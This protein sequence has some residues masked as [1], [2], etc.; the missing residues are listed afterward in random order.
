M[1]IC[2]RV[3]FRIVLTSNRSVFIIVYVPETQESL[4]VCAPGISHLFNDIRLY[5][6]QKVKADE[7]DIGKYKYF[8][9]FLSLWLLILNWKFGPWQLLKSNMKQQ[10]FTPNSILKRILLL[11]R[12]F[13]RQVFNTHCLPK[14]N[15]RKIRKNK[16]KLNKQRRL[17]KGQF[18]SFRKIKSINITTNT[19]T[20]TKCILHHI[21]FL[22]L[23]MI[24]VI[25]VF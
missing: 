3:D 20:C 15:I 8:S 25:P 10:A 16:R 18:R 6:K 21:S 7:Q 17:I 4:D 11:M 5:C 22:F 23:E 19:N 12:I 14:R 1:G 9:Y 24:F 2:Q 13:F